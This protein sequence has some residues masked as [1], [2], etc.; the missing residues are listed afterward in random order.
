MLDRYRE[1]YGGDPRELGEDDATLRA[2]WSELVMEWIVE[3]RTLLDETGPSAMYE[4]RKLAV[5]CGPNQEWNLGYGI[6]VGA[7]GRRQLVDI[8]VPYPRG[9]EQDADPMSDGVAEMAAAL[10]GTDVQLL[11][12]LG[13]YADHRMTV[14]Q[15]C[16]RADAFYRAGATGLSRWDTDHWMARLQL[17]SA[18]VQRLWAEHY[19][20]PTNAIVSTAGVNRARFNPRIGV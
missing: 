18:T 9:I 8:V 11:P 14:R 12:S 7:W 15:L 4:R 1:R 6:D 16:A 3:L 10:E 20:P 17:E 13:S 5:I 2:V 19:M